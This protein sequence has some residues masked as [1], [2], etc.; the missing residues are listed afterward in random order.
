[1]AASVAFLEAAAVAIVRC[2]YW[3]YSAAVAAVDLAV[4]V[5]GSLAA[6]KA[7]VKQLI[8]SAAIL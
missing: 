1:M 2:G 3:L 5:A 4:V 8:L 6:A 7:E